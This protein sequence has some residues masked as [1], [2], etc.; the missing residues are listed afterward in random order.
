MTAKESYKERQ[1]SEFEVLKVRNPDD[2]F[3]H[4]FQNIFS[5]FMSSSKLTLQSIFNEDVSDLRPKQEKWIPLDIKIELSPQKDS[6]VSQAFCG[7]TLHLIC[8][9]NYPKV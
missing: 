7:V 2:M 8:P 6:K 9:K 4:V 5:Y 1:E 3:R